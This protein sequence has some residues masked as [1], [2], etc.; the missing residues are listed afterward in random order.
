[1][2][3]SFITAPCH[4]DRGVITRIASMPQPNNIR[5]AEVY[6]ALAD[7]GPVGHGRPS[8]SVVRVTPDDAISYR[9]HVNSLGI[10]LTYLLNAP[11]K[12]KCDHDSQKELDTY[13]D[14]VL[15]GLRPD[16]VTVASLDLMQEVRKMD[17]D[18]DIHIS[19]IAS[20]KSANELRKYLHVNP[21]RVVVHHD[22]GKDWKAL[23][24]VVNEGNRH[25]IDVEMLT[26]E[27]CLFHCPQREQHY[28]F[29]SKQRLGDKEFH[30]TCNSRTLLKP[31]E[32]LL[33]GGVIRP[34]D[35]HIYE[36]MGVHYMKITGRNKPVEWLPEVV[37]AYTKRSYS[38][39]LIRLLGIDSALSVEGMLYLNNKALDGY[40]EDF[41]HFGNYAEQ[42]Q[43]GDMWISKL[44][45]EGEFRVG[46]GT[47][48]NVEGGSLVLSSRGENVNRIISRE[49]S[50]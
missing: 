48:Y 42:R 47:T 30:T 32:L 43:Y 3:N 19:T 21:N 18:I 39:N 38:G 17:Q 25:N 27:G 35:V 41:P 50:L 5:I 13:L 16:A 46:D 6:G 8:D 45:S 4:W 44:Y 40:L 2:R 28:E 22:L 20:V 36:D 12:K 7:G 31:R 1:M 24:E 34:E 11:Y 29:L 37:E 10:K 23:R 15:N 9:E 14:W 49:R 33:A 26:T